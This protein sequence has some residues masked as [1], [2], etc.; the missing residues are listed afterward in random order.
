MLGNV[1]CKCNLKHFFNIIT[2]LEKNGKKVE[3][4]KY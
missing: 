1:D 3:L 2:F 4:L